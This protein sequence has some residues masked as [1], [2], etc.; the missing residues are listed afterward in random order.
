[1]AGLFGGMALGAAIVLM[2][3]I[4]VLISALV[5]TRPAATT[6]FAKQAFYIPLAIFLGVSLVFGV[7]GLIIGK[8]GRR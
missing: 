7:I 2:Y 6:Y 1:M 5:G 3:G 4:F 8:M